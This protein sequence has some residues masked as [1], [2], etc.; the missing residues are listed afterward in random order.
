M[1]K[2]NK[3][4]K[5]ES[6]FPV[7]IG[8]NVISTKDCKKLINEIKNI[9]AFDDMIQGGRSRINKGSK[10]FKNYISKSKLSS[11]LFKQFNSKV[12]YKKVEVK[13]KK[14]FKNYDWSNTYLPKSFLSKKYTIKKPMNSKELLRVFG[15]SYK[16]PK[17]NLD[18]DFSVSVGGYRLRPH[19]DDITRL[20][21]FLIYL[22]DIPK[23]N[24]GSLTI[25]K[26][27][28]DKRIRK[29]FRRFPNISELTKVKE[30]I[31]TKGSVIFFQS[32]PNSYHGVKLFRETKGL[33]R[34]FIYGS[35]ALSK[36]VVWRYKD[37]TYFPFI[38]KTKKKLLT[39]SHDSD[40]LLK[41]TG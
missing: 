36:P 39:S 3:L 26:K 7:M 15:N 8:K 30:F 19:R 25:F 29:T 11:K 16:N 9:K 10:N 18:I 17:V 6:H 23:K 28:V 31:P 24:G 41:E 2:I 5:I 38:K 1:I 12:F 32:T 33:K 22:N 4:K 40:Y 21:N 20:Y 35:Y 14:T 13:F 27:K 34:F 37:V